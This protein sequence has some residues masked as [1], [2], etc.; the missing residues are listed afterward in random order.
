MP[1]SEQTEFH[2]PKFVRKPS[3]TSPTN[4]RNSKA[5]PSRKDSRFTAVVDED[6]DE[7]VLPD[8]PARDRTPLRSMRSRGGGAPSF[9]S[10]TETL[11]KMAEE[12]CRLELK[13]SELDSEL[14]IAEHEESLKSTNQG[15]IST[16]EKKMHKQQMRK[17]R[18]F[19]MAGM[20]KQTKRAISKKH[21]SGSLRLANP[22]RFLDKG[23]EESNYELFYDALLVVVIVKLSYMQQHDLTASGLLITGALFANFWSCW[24]LLNTYVTMLHTDDL[25]HR[26]YYLLHIVTSMAMIV[27]I[28][29][30]EFT[31]F[32][33]KYMVT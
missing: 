21:T 27:S 32:N 19:A 26:V 29:N 18:T 7:S 15:G 30:P 33:V 11:T 4:I 6:R 13:L 3:D 17:I 16:I 22:L 5:F 1:L 28:H 25:V 31:F 14:A 9:L 8:E 20:S 24:N 10:P 2:E 23:H 12:K